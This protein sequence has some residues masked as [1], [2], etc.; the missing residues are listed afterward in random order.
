MIPTPA[1][2]VAR[3]NANMITL[4]DGLSSI[5]NMYF[6]QPIAGAFYAAVRRR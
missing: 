2:F 4:A 1:G 3:D 6:W 5:T